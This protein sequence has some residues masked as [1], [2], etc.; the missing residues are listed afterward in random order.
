ML[1]VKSAGLYADW[2]LVCLICLLPSCSFQI[3]PICLWKME[4]GFL[5]VCPTR[6]CFT[7]TLAEI[8]VH[9]ETSRPQY[10]WL[11]WKCNTQRLQ[12][13]LCFMKW[14]RGMAKCTWASWHNG[15][16]IRFRFIHRVSCWWFWKM[17]TNC[18]EQGCCAFHP[19][20][21][22]FSWTH[23]GLSLSQNAAILDK[24][25]KKQMAASASLPAVFSL[26][27]IFS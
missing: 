20:S 5:H 13:S 23:P 19:K 8:W 6:L 7:L 17:E 25:M 16:S 2:R 10:M 22:S 12:R 1:G 14:L 15:W 26:R 21:G 9:S 18:S 27:T 11:P 4:H 24:F 3:K